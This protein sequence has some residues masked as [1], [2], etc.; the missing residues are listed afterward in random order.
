M[1]HSLC[2]FPSVQHCMQE[3]HQQN[4]LWQWAILSAEHVLVII[5]TFK[6]N[7]LSF[8]DHP[9]KMRKSC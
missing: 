5:V 6:I 7:R 4:I 2:T 3:L 9:Q 1:R 8:Q